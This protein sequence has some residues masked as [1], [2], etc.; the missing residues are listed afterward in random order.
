MP[1]SIKDAIAHFREMEAW[2][3]GRAAE[4]KEGTQSLLYKHG[5]AVW[6]QAARHLELLYLPY[7]ENVALEMARLKRQSENNPLNNQ[8][9]VKIEYEDGGIERVDVPISGKVAGV[10]DP[11]SMRCVICN[12]TKAFTATGICYDCTT[13][14]RQL[15]GSIER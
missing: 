5:A 13:E 8:K 4:V 11:V 15:A 6:G 3:L 14:A 7:E 1:R 2:S 12:K 9:L 10:K